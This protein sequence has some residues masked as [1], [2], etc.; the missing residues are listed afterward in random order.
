MKKLRTAVCI[1][2]WLDFLNIT[3]KNLKRNVFD[4]LD[5]PD[6]FIYYSEIGKKKIIL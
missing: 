4:Q 5:N 6:I 3:S 1:T 2:G